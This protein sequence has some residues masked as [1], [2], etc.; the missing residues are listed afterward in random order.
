MRRILLTTFGS[1]GDLHPYL[2]MARVLKSHGDQVT[3][4]THEEYREFV[5]RIG[6]RFVPM[7]PGLDEVG[8]QESWS[9][10]ANHSIFGTKFIIQTLIM[11]YLEASY[12]S[13]KIA[14][15]GQDLIISHVLTF[16]A[17]LVAEE[18]QIP[19]VSCALQ[20]S[21]FFSAYDPP[22]LGFMTFLPKLKFLGPRFMR[23]FLKLLSKP[24]DSWLTPIAK[25]RARIGLAHSSKNVLIDGFSPCGT[26]ALFPSVFAPAQPDWPTGVRQIGFPLFDEETT[27]EI[28]APLQQ[29]LDSGSAPVVFTLGTAVVM[30]ET[31]Y[32]EIAY[33]AIERLGLR[34][35][36]L[37]GK[38]PRR[39][40][41]TATT[42]ANIHISKYEPFSR[43]FPRSAVIVHQC[44]IGTTAQAL[45]SGRPQVLVPF[46]HDQ[47]DNARRVVELGAG[48]SIPAHRLNA[49]RLV[50]AI[51]DLMNTE[52]FS[53]QAREIV[54]QLNVSE[55]PQNLIAAI[56]Q[57]LATP[58]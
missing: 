27:G 11:P 48:R 36:F 5:E 58:S 23:W 45:T 51:Q 19:W 26:L 24:T 10:K 52:R 47:P 7:K 1:Y 16:A 53:N 13:L 12:H 57:C 54:P 39:I 35:V 4:A 15:V 38:S 2:A 8:P 32:F 29:F 41:M 55:F 17:P 18:L 34:A 44:G 33:E 6:V 43:L 31:N 3:I 22:A 9:S 25:L 20:P 49:N 37:V 28:S 30:M 40:P 56:T 50:T 21:P 14:A 42:D 46:A